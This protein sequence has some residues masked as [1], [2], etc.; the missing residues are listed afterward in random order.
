[1]RVTGVVRARPEGTANPG[2][3]TGEEFTV[4]VDLDLGG[5]DHLLHY[6]L[7]GTPAERRSLSAVKALY[8]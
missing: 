8:R 5:A 4:R 1:M 6:R 3:P 2:L 7:E